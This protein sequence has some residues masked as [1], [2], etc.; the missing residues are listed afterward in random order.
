LPSSPESEMHLDTSP[1]SKAWWTKNIITIYTNS[2][3]H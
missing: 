1:A 2:S 3:R